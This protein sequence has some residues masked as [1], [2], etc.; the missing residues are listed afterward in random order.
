MC[1]LLDMFSQVSDML[2]RAID[3]LEVPVDRDALVLSCDL[4]DRLTAK[5]VQAVGGVRRG[6][7][8]AG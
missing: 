3:E 8:V 5:V 7:G 6:G 4:L 2:E 1:T